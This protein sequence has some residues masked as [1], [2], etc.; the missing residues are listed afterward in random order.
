MQINGAIL[1]CNQGLKTNQFKFYS[2]IKRV[3]NFI[4][5]RYPIEK[6]DNVKE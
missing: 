6:E 3:E 2:A 5:E 1:G 4:N